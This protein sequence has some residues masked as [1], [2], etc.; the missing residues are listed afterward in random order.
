MVLLPVVLSALVSTGLITSYA[1]TQLERQATEMGEAVAAQLATSL[2]TYL[3]NNDVLSLN[4]VLTDLVGQG[5]FS[6]VSVFSADDRLIA[7]VGKRQ[8]DPTDKVF[9][10]DITLQKV[11]A[12]YLRI[13]LD[14]GPLTDATTR[15]VT[16]VIGWHLLLLLLVGMASWFYLDFIQLWIRLPAAASTTRS[17]AASPVADTHEA[18][19]AA[20]RQTEDALSAPEPS[21]DYSLLL[22]KIQ[23]GRRL[24]EHRRRLEQAVT[25]YQG[26]VEAADTDTMRL[27]FFDAG[28]ETHAVF[29]GLLILEMFRLISQPI[30]VKSALTVL[31]VPRQDEPAAQGKGPAAGGQEDTARL[32]KQLSYLASISDNQLLVTRSFR[33]Q[34]QTGTGIL[35]QPFHSSLAPEGEVFQVTALEPAQ[36]KLITNQ[37]SQLVH[38]KQP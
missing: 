20:D 30:T 3:V 34:L 5:H 16:M 15:I 6:Q 21:Q 8:T 1:Q 35:L 12:G 14:Q 22:I 31:P 11:S 32:I 24:A 25:L 18:S 37:A 7:Q 4:V 19:P 2:A 17:A 36:Q 27:A 9:S 33:S 29:T 10:R 13:V 23:P 28:H 26:S 38:Q